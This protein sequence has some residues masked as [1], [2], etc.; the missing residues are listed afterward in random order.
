MKGKRFI[1]TFGL[2]VVLAIIVVLLLFFVREKTRSYLVELR[3]FAP[4]LAV[5]Q[6]ELA[7]QNVS[8]YD[9]AGVAAQIHQVDALLTR[10]LFLMKV[11]LPMVIFVLAFFVSFMI[12]RFLVKVSFLQ[13]L[14]YS[15]PFYGG[16]FL[17]VS[18]FFQVLSFFLVGA[19]ISHGFL[20]AFLLALLLVYGH[21]YLVSI[22]NQR[23]VQE[24]FRAGMHP[25]KRFV[26]WYLLFVFSFVLSVA[27]VVLLFI[28]SWVQ[29][30]ILIPSI[31]LVFTLAGMALVRFKLLHVFGHPQ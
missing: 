7:T 9:A 20:F 25:K 17:A 1:I 16:M 27:L 18:L 2:D 10:G 4:Q 29:V 24:N 5:L 19:G 15:L 28:L 6:Q 21:F 30:S 31:L 3:A 23:S 11:I 22:L 14:A 8:T 13:F 26:G 12:W